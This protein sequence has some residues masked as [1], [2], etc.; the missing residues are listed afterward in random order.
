M[1]R[2]SSLPGCRSYH[3][4][5]LPRRGGSFSISDRR[6]RL[7]RNADSHGEQTS[8]GDGT[9]IL[10]QWDVDYHPCCDGGDETV[11][12]G[13]GGGRTCEACTADVGPSYS[14]CHLSAGCLRKSICNFTSRH[15]LTLLSRQSFLALQTIALDVSTSSI[16]SNLPNLTP[17]PGPPHPLLLHPHLSRRSRLHRIPNRSG[18]LLRRHHDRLRPS[19]PLPASPTTIRDYQALSV[20]HGVVSDYIWVVPCHGSGE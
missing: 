19:L 13:G 7:T 15:A 5:L 14:R 10:C 11:D 3:W 12:S 17:T 2:R 8:D 16:S 4:N 18:P 6:G 1:L 9:S 20:A